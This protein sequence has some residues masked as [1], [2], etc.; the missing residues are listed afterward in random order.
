MAGA[1]REDDAYLLRELALFGRSFDRC[2]FTALEQ[3]PGRAP[4]LFWIA[5]RKQGRHRDLFTQGICDLPA[6]DFEA[7][8]DSLSIAEAA[9]LVQ[10]LASTGRKP[11]RFVGD[12]RFASV[13]RSAAATPQTLGTAL[14]SLVLIAQLWDDVRYGRCALLDF[15]PGERESTAEGFRAALASRAAR[16]AVD[17][18]MAARPID[19]DLIWLRRQID[20]AA[21]TVPEA[22]QAGI[23]IRVTVPLPSSGDDARSNVLVDGVPIIEQLYSHGFR[24]SP[25]QVLQRG[26]GLQATSEPRD[27]RL[28]EGTCVEACCGA[29]RTVIRRDEAAGRVH[30]E[31][32]DTGESD[33]AL[34][35]F[36]FDAAAYDAEVSRAA[37]DFSWEWPARRAARL[38]RERILAEPELLSRWDCR[39]GWANSWSSERSTARLV[40]SHPSTLPT[41]LDQP[42]IQFEYTA[43]VPDSAVND[44]AAEAVV[45][46]IVAMLRSTD[47]KTVSRVCGGS[48]EHAEALGYSWPPQR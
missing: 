2:A 29:L 7:L 9:S 3:I 27:V 10:M 20:L 36:D 44:G 35:R 40:F 23:A 13:L 19:G 6:E 42:W 34:A 12:R 4:H 22:L 24:D 5:S 46:R 18:E 47:P 37:G 30:W 38:V 39:L 15:Q 33:A 8:L 45:E 21:R 26:Q 31:V 32:R 17:R 14:D 41:D 1:A 16:D 28:S 43:D 11:P 48:R 25:E